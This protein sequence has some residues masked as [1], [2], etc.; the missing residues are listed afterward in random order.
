MAA[1]SQRIERKS[2]SGPHNIQRDTRKV[3][4]KSSIKEVFSVFSFNST[5]IILTGAR[6]ILRSLPSLLSPL[7]SNDHQALADIPGRPP[8][9]RCQ[10]GDHQP[11]LQLRVAPA[12]SVHHHH[13]QPRPRV[14]SDS[15]SITA[16]GVQ[17]P[18]SD[19]PAPQSQSMH[20]YLNKIKMV[21]TQIGYHYVTLLCLIR[22]STSKDL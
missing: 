15:A 16:S 5:S 4:I 11:L 8:S 6:Q 1:C 14:P 21:D 7:L 3:W 20:K 22:I 2:D 13:A 9:P 12:P 10:Q 19:R 18:L 17:E